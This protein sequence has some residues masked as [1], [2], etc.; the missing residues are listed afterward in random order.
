MRAAVAHGRPWAA[1]ALHRRHFVRRGLRPTPAVRAS[2]LA[3]ALAPCPRPVFPGSSGLGSPAPGGAHRPAHHPAPAALDAASEPTLGGSSGADSG[4]SPL[5]AA[6]KAIEGLRGVS[7]WSTLELS[8]ALGWASLGGGGAG[9]AWPGLSGG[10]RPL[11]DVCAWTAEA[12]SAAGPLRAARAV[13]AWR[14]TEGAPVDDNWAASAVRLLALPTPTAPPRPPAPAASAP[15]NPAAFAAA[16]A[17]DAAWHRDWSDDATWPLHRPWAWPLGLPGLEGANAAAARAGSSWRARSAAL[18]RLVTAS[19]Q[20]RRGDNLLQGGIALSPRSVVKN[21][22]GANRDGDDGGGGLAVGPSA[23]PSYVA[24]LAACE[25][26]ALVGDAALADRFAAQAAESRARARERAACLDDDDDDDDGHSAASAASV[27]AAGPAPRALAAAAAARTIRVRAALHGKP[28]GH[29]PPCYG[30][31]AGFE[32]SG[33]AAA[34]PGGGGAVSGNGWAGPTSLLDGAGW[35]ACGPGAWYGW[36]GEGWG[37]DATPGRWGPAGP[38]GAALDRGGRWDRVA[39][40]AAADW[41]EGLAVL[42]AGLDT[43]GRPEPTGGDEDGSPDGS[44]DAD[45]GTARP[46]RRGRFDAATPGALGGASGTAPAWPA[47]RRAALG[48]GGE[49][50]VWLGSAAARGRVG[51]GL[52]PRSLRPPLPAS[53]SSGPAPLPTPPA[54][55]ATLSAATLGL[56]ETSLD[57]VAAATGTDAWRDPA[58]GGRDAAPSSPPP[59]RAPVPPWARGLESAAAALVAASLGAPEGTAGRGGGGTTFP[60]LGLDRVGATALVTRAAETLRRPEA[61]AVLLRAALVDPLRRGRGGLERAND[62]RDRDRDRDRDD[63]DVGA[64]AGGWRLGHRA[65]DALKA[66]RTAL[67]RGGGEGG[68]DRRLERLLWLE[69][70]R[71]AR[72]AAPPGTA[73]Q[74]SPR[75]AEAGDDSERSGAPATWAGDALALLAE[76]RP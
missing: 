56:V 23:P 59:P 11:G 63:V 8:A 3:A 2:L 5:L 28:L 13:A 62:D 36:R 39:A 27:T 43:I 31:E 52:R 19:G 46:R 7:G 30:A 60:P 16:K 67:G 64:R 21:G 9:R 17:A 66:R 1:L 71:R 74:K 12:E 73:P 25:S 48:D 45:T 34:D 51:G 57:L 75:G 18:A 32:S 20:L 10:G 68:G 69:L 33:A 37:G 24:A 47:L 76:A 35:G 4:V 15:A 53:P 65:A 42:V 26:A 55:L 50:A 41:R 40:R 22:G 61:V 14:A 38:G 70:E 58:T 6:G 72:A 54:Q 44:P 29:A 49:G